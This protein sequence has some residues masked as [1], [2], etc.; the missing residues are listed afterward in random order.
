MGQ[1]AGLVLGTANNILLA[2]LLGPANF[3]L[4]AIFLKTCN[5]AEILSQLGTNASTVKLV[6]IAAGAGD[7]G[8]LKGI[9]HSTWRIIIASSAITA[10]IIWITRRPLSLQVFNSPELGGILAFGVA[11]IPLQ[12]GLLL[13]RETF[14]GL[15]DLKIVSFLPV[16]Q[17]LVLLAALAILSLKVITSIQ[18][19]LTAFCTGVF[20]A[21]AAGL[22]LLR[23][24]AAHW[25]TAAE[26]VDAT[27]ILAESLPMM[28]TRGSLLAISSMDVLVLGMHANSFEVGIY[29]A[30]SNL[31]ATSVFSLGIINQVI[32]ALIAHYHAQKDLQTLAYVARYASTVGALFS[33]PVF[34]LLL[35][36]GKPVLSIVFGPQYAGGILALNFLLIGQ[37]I[38]SVTGSCGYMLQM[39]GQHM[40]LMKISIAC[41]MLNLILN[42]VLARYF[43]K[44]GVAAATALSLVMQNVLSVIMA[45]KKTGIWTMA[46]MEMTIEILKQARRYVCTLFSR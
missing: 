41:G 10:L 37:L 11:L 46:S 44:E 15:Q 18:S 34:I 2:R 7:W 5:V 17:Q 30:V 16:L 20:C 1:A 42:F 12:N 9:L 3:G 28:V 24:R 4:Y 14:R 36:F 26:K 32:P 27:A 6:G 8:R 21:L 19:V 45:R 38:N 13:V 43:G 31:A 22:L 29:S 23:R 39:T 35:L 33:F 40:T 25:K